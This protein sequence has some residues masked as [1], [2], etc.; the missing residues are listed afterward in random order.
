MRSSRSCITEVEDD[1]GIAIFDQ[2]MEKSEH[3]TDTTI[4]LSRLDCLIGL[5]CIDKV[6]RKVVATIEMSKREDDEY[7][8]CSSPR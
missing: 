8:V 4:K 7:K 5:F 6:R 1:S 2:Q 3:P